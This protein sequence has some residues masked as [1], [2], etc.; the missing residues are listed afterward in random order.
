[1]C[2]LYSMT[3]G[4]AAIRDLACAM[5]DTT[6]NLPPMPGIFPDYPAPI[7]R[8]DGDGTRALVIARW[9]MPSSKKALFDQATKRADKQRARGGEVDFAQ[10]L[11]LEPDRGTTNVRNTSS[12]HWRPWLGPA[13]RCLVPVTS[14][15]EPD[16]A[17]GSPQPVWF[18]LGE[19]RP[20]AFFAG[21]WTTWTGVRK[22]KEG[23]V[24]SELFAFLT[25]TPNA[26]VASVHPKA[27][28]VVLTEPDEWEMWMAAPWLE[29]AVLQRPL[30]DGTLK[31]VARGAKADA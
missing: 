19:D 24:T 15:S 29:A 8:T 28:P 25:T 31:V 3:K 13:H 17:S 14:F 27:M 4:Q 7:V 16:H 10:L 22:A 2:N 6:G 5:R 23:E 20:L 9:G 26:E 21:I 1:M 18:A 12:S 11:R 30:P